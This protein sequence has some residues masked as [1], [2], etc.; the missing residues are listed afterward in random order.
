MLMWEKSGNC[1]RRICGLF[2]RDSKGQQIF[3]SM[4]NS[5]ASKVWYQKAQARGWLSIIPGRISKYNGLV[6]IFFKQKENSMA[7]IV[8]V[9]NEQISNEF[10][11][12]CT[13]GTSRRS[14]IY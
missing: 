6:A 5:E 11:V 3:R 1:E 14:K 10:S 8:L 7:E 2:L 12:D 13:E 4:G 9:M